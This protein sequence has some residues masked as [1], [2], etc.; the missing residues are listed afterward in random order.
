MEGERVWR[1]FYHSSISFT[2]ELGSHFHHFLDMYLHH[3]I[4]EIPC[5]WSTSIRATRHEEVMHTRLRIEHT[6]LTYSYLLNLNV[7]SC[8]HCEDKHLIVIIHSSPALAYL[9]AVPSTSF[10]A[11]P[12]L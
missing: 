3:S 11:S 2:Q 5:P 6:R 12:L 8:P 9:F 4:E 7:L 1:Y 10:S